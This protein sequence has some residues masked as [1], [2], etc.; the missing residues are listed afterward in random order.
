MHSVAGASMY[1]MDTLLGTATFTNG[2]S[3]LIMGIP[4]DGELQA[5]DKILLRQ[6]D[7][8]T[9][10]MTTSSV[11][12]VVGVSVS[13]LQ[14][15]V[16]ES[17]LVQT[18]VPVAVYRQQSRVIPSD[19]SVQSV[20][21]KLETLAQVR[22]VTVGRQG[23][24]PFAAYT[25]TVSF[26]SVLSLDAI[27]ASASS[28][29]GVNVVCADATLNGFYVSDSFS[30]GRRSYSLVDSPFSLSFETTSAKWRLYALNN[31]NQPIDEETTSSNVL[32]PWLTAAF[33]QCSVAQS[34]SPV[35]I[36]KG[37]GADASLTLAQ[38]SISPGLSSFIS[39]DQLGPRVNEVQSV[40]VTSS[41]GLLF[42]GF[43]LDFN[44][45]L[46]HLAFRA[47]ESAYDFRTKLQSLPTV[48]RVSVSRLTLN[49]T[50]GAFSGY[51]YTH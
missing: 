48:G 40:T 24:S 39:S 1:V 32:S 34:L 35:V 46:V 16:M 8:S 15:D 3:S 9:L 30:G 27:S 10:T 11:L 33:S 51:V 42:G 5:G 22:S 36:L 47:D 19:A 14:V 13:G 49:N 25:W 43:E 7:P 20:Q 50:L 44:A 45:S 31:T 23:P 6:I 38:S 17:I 2:T 29:T 26:T 4:V 18:N 28:S 37:T 12:T 41:D 21:Q